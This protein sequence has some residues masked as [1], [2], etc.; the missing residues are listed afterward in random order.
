MKPL[1]Y[2][3]LLLAGLT[4]AG[5]AAGVVYT[6]NTRADTH[7]VNPAI[8][9]VDAAGFTSLRSATEAANYHASAAGSAHTINL[10][11]GTYNLTNGELGLGNATNLAIFIHG[12]GPAAGTLVQQTTAARVF[13]LNSTAVSGFIC[14]LDNLTLSNGTAVV[15]GGGAILCGGPN[16]ALSLTN[17][18]LSNNRT[19][20]TAG[21]ALACAAGGNLTVVGCVF[22]NNTATN[23]T[24]GAIDFEPQGQ[25]GNLVI[26]SSTFSGNTALQTNMPVAGGALFLD[27]TVGNAFTLSQ[28]AFVG[29]SATGGS[30]AGGAIYL[31]NGSL[32]ANECRL[33]NNAAAV[34]SAI[35]RADL[36]VG[37]IDAA[38]N[39][40]GVNTGPGPAVYGFTPT[41][42]LTLRVVPTLTTLGFNA[43]TTFTADIRA[44]NNGGVMGQSYL[45]NLPAFPPT[46]GAI[47]GGAQLGTLSGAVGQMV[48]GGFAA[49]FTSGNSCGLGLAVATVDSQSVTGSVVISAAGPVAVCAGTT[50]ALSGTFPGTATVYGTNLDGGST[51]ACGIALREVSRD[52]VNFSNSVSFTCAETGPQT[53]Y[54]RVTDTIGQASTCSTSV[55]VHDVTPPVVSCKGIVLSLNANGQA[56][57]TPADVDNGSYDNCGIVFRSVQPANFTCANLGPN[58]V[59]LTVAD[60][61]GHT[62]QCTTSVTV[63]DGI[64]PTVV[65]PGSFSTNLM[66]GSN[67]MAVAFAVSA[68]DNCGPLTPQCVPPSGAGFPA[69][70]TFVTCTA[71]DAAGNSNACSFAVTVCASAITVL[72]AN[73]SGP[74]SLRQ[75]LLD[76]CPDGTITFHPSLSGQMIYLTSG[77]LSLAQNLTITGPGANL[78][79]VSGSQVSRVFS[80]LPGVSNAISGL[81]I[82]NGNGVGPDYAGNGGGIL[83]LGDLNLEACAL[84]DNA[85]D[86]STGWGGAIYSIGHLRLL[87]CTIGPGNS[88]GSVAGG[89]VADGGS[90]VE[91]LNC[92][93]S[94]N[95]CG[96]SVGGVA[97]NSGGA[98][99]LTNCTITANSDVNFAG[100]YGGMGAALKNTLIA[101]NTSG[102]PSLSDCA[103][104]SGSVFSLG[105]NLIGIADS[106]G[107]W[108]ASD[109]TGYSTLPLD[110]RLG[111][112]GNNGGPTL[113]HALLISPNSPA[114]NAGL[115]TDAPPYDQRGPGF[116]RVAGRAIDIGAFELIPPA[117]RV[118]PLASKVVLT[119][120]GD[121]AGYSVQVATNLAPLPF[122]MPA[123][124]V[125]VLQAGQYRLTNALG[126]ENLFFRLVAY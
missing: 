86:P 106:V 12:T 30:G 3:L 15:L 81:S 58:T 90:V 61:A 35:A 66:A 54:L 62:N 39:W 112:L 89:V 48:G 67:S 78:L 118:T 77:E 110:P 117:L 5:A 31:A 105:G 111:P 6:V 17:C 19:R 97:V 25:A 83:N 94:G 33:V 73:D 84:S 93:V 68:I 40:W 104:F 13:S 119:W 115:S 32:A 53:V 121:V 4:P 103:T 99:I 11:P 122:W 88:A 34:G 70:T 49:S 113:T 7:A 69:G 50:V 51:S 63:V 21:G 55:I 44:V 79:T 36:A 26:Q 74:G 46:P 28:S 96:N 76:L 98:A 20:N 16:N 91:M 82:M 64:P 114:L 124:G 101:G 107:G 43:S 8:S 87:A 65:C 108:L 18:V 56:T 41:L 42:W 47:F 126:A 10:P 102:N 123:P 45:A 60:A 9:S 27:G 100:G 57:L 92:S 125:P 120:P 116:P 72:N 29:N 59:T 23:N 24:G 85:A 75:A 52:G 37:T 38:A 22:A 71:R 95:W 80:V 109:R 2:T 1:L 14:A